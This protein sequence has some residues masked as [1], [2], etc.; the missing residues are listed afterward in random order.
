MS[1]VNKEADSGQAAANA[2]KTAEKAGY[3]PKQADG[4]A[5]AAQETVRIAQ[6]VQRVKMSAV[7]GGKN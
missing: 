3:N 4:A 2:I 1:Q 6:A 5:K 7:S